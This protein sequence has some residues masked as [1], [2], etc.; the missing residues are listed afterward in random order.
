MSKLDNHKALQRK[1]KR[2]RDFMRLKEE[3]RHHCLIELAQIRKLLLCI[4]HKL[5]LD[6]RIFQLTI[7]EVK[8]LADPNAHLQLMRTADQR[9]EATFGL[10]VFTTA[11]RFVDT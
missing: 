4:D 9:L 10:E 5:Q 7:D 6:G 3:A 11:S 8:E 1:V 2:A